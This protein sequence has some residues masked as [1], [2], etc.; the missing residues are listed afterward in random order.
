ME[1][2]AIGKAGETAMGLIRDVDLFINDTAPFTLAKDE[3][4]RD[5]LGAIL[6][7]CLEVLRMATNMLLPLMPE[8]MNEFH[9]AIGCVDSTEQPTFDWGG[10]KAGTLVSKI[11]LFPR[12]DQ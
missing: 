5:E 9:E 7:Q 3:T 6:Y 12:V 2:F 10:L 8:K 11:A 1:R 4:R